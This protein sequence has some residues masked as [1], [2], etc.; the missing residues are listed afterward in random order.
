LGSSFLLESSSAPD[1]DSKGKHEEKK[2][3]QSQGYHQLEKI[4]EANVERVNE[5][6]RTGRC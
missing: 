3:Q 2:N 5:L 1:R 4:L 6:T